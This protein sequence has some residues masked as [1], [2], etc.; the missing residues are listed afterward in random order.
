MLRGRTDRERHPQLAGR[1]DF[2]LQGIGICRHRH[3]HGSKDD[4]GKNWPFKNRQLTGHRFAPRR[5][6]ARSA[7]ALCF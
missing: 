3:Q 6:F 2:I 4:A 7:L 5:V 1:R